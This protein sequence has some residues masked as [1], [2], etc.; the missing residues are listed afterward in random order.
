M[1]ASAGDPFGEDVRVRSRAR[2]SVLGGD[3]DVTAS[4][5]AVLD[6]AVEAFGGLPRHRLGRRAARLAVHLALNDR[7]TSWAD[8]GAPPPPAHSSGAGLL[9][10]TIDAG[11][12]AIVDAGRSRALVSVSKALLR[13][14]YYP[15]YELIE[16]AFVALASRVQRLVPLHAACIG[17]GGNGVLLMGA[18]GAGKSTLSL[19]ALAGG[20]QLLSEDSAFVALHGLRVTG[21]PSYLHLAPDALRF[22]PPGPLRRSIERARTIERRSGARKLEVDLRTLGAATARTAFRLAAVVFLS[23]RPAGRARALAPLGREAVARQLRRE[24]PYALRRAAGW[25][26]FERRVAGVPAYE[27]RRT[28][29]PDVAVEQLRGLLE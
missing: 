18:S 17:L 21:V 20:L 6:L 13:Q 19:H 7:P 29:H 28:E 14:P 3:F 15:R 9:C 24:Q 5:R 23:R 12:F 22:L 11:N 2:L 1:K 10:A 27:L 8:G 25:N 16:L 4:H 26:D